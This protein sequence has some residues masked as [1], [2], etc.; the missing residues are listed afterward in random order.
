MRSVLRQFA[1]SVNGDD[2]W[3]EVDGF[4]H[5]VLFHRQT[6]VKTDGD[7]IGTRRVICSA[8]LIWYRLM[9]TSG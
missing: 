2:Q 7:L 3:L 5:D 4:D 8:L 9:L 1:V 6:A